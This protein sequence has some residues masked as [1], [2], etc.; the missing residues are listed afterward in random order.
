MDASSGDA[1][2]FVDAL[3]D[4]MEGEPGVEGL[5][6]GRQKVKVAELRREALSSAKPWAESDLENGVGEY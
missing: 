1:S 5:R 3:Q 6:V 4:V 2:V